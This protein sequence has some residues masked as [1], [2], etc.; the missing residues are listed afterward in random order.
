MGTVRFRS[1]TRLRPILLGLVLVACS[2]A[3]T[4]GGGGQG[5]AAGATAGTGGTGT[6]GVGGSA[7][8]AGAA[9]H[10]GAGG[11]AGSSGSG[12]GGGHG[13]GT[14]GSGGSPGGMGGSGGSSGGMSG[15]GGSGGSD[16]CSSENPTGT[17]ED[18]SLSCFCC[19][20]DK[21]T[22]ICLCTVACMEDAECTNPDLPL[23]NKRPGEGT[24]FCSSEHLH[25]CWDC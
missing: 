14:A 8:S 22:Q 19:P 3:Q 21:A 4:G 18:T 16:L 9:G 6:A 5:A 7:G 1:M 15:S 12:G 23:C 2:E 13:G 25:C 17:C 20:F 24:G 11:S 10:A